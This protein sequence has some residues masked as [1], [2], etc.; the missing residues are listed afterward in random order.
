MKEDS[1]FH[2]FEKKDIAGITIPT[3]FTYPFHYTPHPLCLLASKLLQ[4]YIGTRNEWKDELQH[5]KMLG[6]LIVKNTFDELGFLAA[7]SGNLVHRNDHEYF[8]PAV[9][10]LLAE[11][12]F[13][14]IEES[15]ISDINKRIE[16][17]LSSDERKSIVTQLSATEDSAR[18]EIESYKQLMKDAKALRDEQRKNG[19]ANE[20]LIAESQF[21]KA[22]L[23]R[24]QARWK[25]SIEA[26]TAKLAIRDKLIQEW[27]T[28]RQARSAALQERIFRHFILLNACGES[29]DLCDIFADT[30]QHTPPAGAGECAAPKLLQYAYKNGY[31]PIAMAEFW[32]G[33]SPC[34]EIRRHGCFYPSC[35][36]KCEPI[37]NWM[38]QG[39][40][41]EPNPLAKAQ[42]NKPISILYEDEWLIIVN[43][44]E[45]ILSVPGKLS[46]DS[47]QERVQNMFP[48]SQKPIIVHRLDMATSGVLIFAKT[49]AVHKTM[50]AMFKSR[51]IKKRYIALLDGII[52]QQEGTI[53]LP[54]I[55]NPNERPRQIVSYTHGKAAVTQYEVLK[56]EQGLT[57]IAF[58]PLTGRT[59]QLRVHAAHPNGL[60]CPILGDSLYG[61]H[62]DRLYLH[63]ESIDF[64]HPI[65]SKS[66]HVT[67]PCPF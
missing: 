10:D 21:Q 30:P 14:R 20:R 6:V 37:L 61:K 32:V 17:E 46:T 67:S 9:Y 50:Q 47:V 2:R 42:S 28:E 54:L 55:L 11:K 51:A 25:Q 66:V 34:D 44:P 8:V 15:H 43:K 56:Q 4:N 59:H 53:E 58:Y 41:V 31:K 26:L 40:D 18:Q 29:R 63:A 16:Q 12:G 23:K 62:A 3:Q 36:A 24:I 65:T 1:R 39:L 19:A 22:E 52:P 60:D 38:M 5:G 33:D 64:T 57:R 27:K 48:N 49:Q 45:G 7:F 35:K 13:F